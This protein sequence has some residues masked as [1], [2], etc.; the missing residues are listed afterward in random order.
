M[1]SHR[2]VLSVAIVVVLLAVVS[3]PVI[4][5]YKHWTA[6][7]ALESRNSFGLQ[8]EQPPLGAWINRN[9]YTKLF[10]TVPHVYFGNTEVS[11]GDAIHL[12]RLRGLRS[13]AFNGCTDEV[14][15]KLPTHLTSLNLLQ[16]D[17]P[18]SAIAWEQIGKMQ[19]LGSL[20]I[21]GVQRDPMSAPPNVAIKPH[22]SVDDAF[23]SAVANKPR[24]KG[25][26][27]IELSIPRPV[28][29][30]LLKQT[31][32][33]EILDLGGVRGLTEEDLVLIQQHGAVQ[34]LALDNVDLTVGCIE[35]IA[36]MNSLKIFCSEGLSTNLAS[37]LRALRPDLEIET[38]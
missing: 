31:P 2:W 30:K 22:W 19:R 25:L 9:W 27:L 23:L 24:L 17:L 20:S 29:R 3:L 14:W 13:L 10:G 28:L 35:Q 18:P 6:A 12:H 8:Y 32:H 7:T 15:V 37:K 1:W 16:N 21:D 36:T 11:I 34:S 38:N 5:L 26:Y 4:T 33:L